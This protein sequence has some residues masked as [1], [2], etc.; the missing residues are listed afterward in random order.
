MRLFFDLF[1]EATDADSEYRPFV[2]A[3]NVPLFALIDEAT[4]TE[5]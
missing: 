3:W 2:V 1:D 5:S 4:D